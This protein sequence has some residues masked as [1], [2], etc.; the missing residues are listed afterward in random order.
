MNIPDYLD[1]LL[2]KIW[3]ESK[4]V[5]I[6]LYGS[7][8]RNDF[9]TDSDYEIGIV[10]KRD[11]GWSRQKLSEMNSFNSV[12]IYPFVWE[13]LKSG[14]IDTPFPKAIYLQSL[15][16]SGV[17]LYG[18]KLE[19]IIKSKKFTKEDLIESVSFSLGR[20]YSAVVSSR[21]NDWVTVRDSFT[22]SNLY[23]LQILVYIKTGKLVYSYVEMKEKSVDFI[24]KEY[25]ELIDHV[26]EVRKGN[27]VVLN[28]LLY[29]NI[30]FLNKVVLG[31]AKKF[32]L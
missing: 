20:A 23:G 17:V 1:E 5:S 22:K 3:E 30:S 19:K 21:Q 26:I 14:E 9:E 10:Y 8:A 28:P 6:F 18:E 7:M 2:K 11:K 16:N 15:V 29:K 13:E 4:P 31:A 24:D 25:R 12:K 32:G 27:E